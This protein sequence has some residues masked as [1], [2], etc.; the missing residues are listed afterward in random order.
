MKHPYTGEQCT[1]LSSAMVLA[2]TELSQ[3]HP[4]PHFIPNVRTAVAL[5][6]RGWIER[7]QVAAPLDTRSLYFITR[8]GVTALKIGARDGGNHARS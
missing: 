7:A 8:A 3:C 4:A 5:L 6:N 2:L 1:G